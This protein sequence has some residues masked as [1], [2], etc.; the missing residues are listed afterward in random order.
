MDKA[1]KRIAKN[2]IYTYLSLIINFLA[3]LYTSRIVLQVLG[4]S[5]YGIYNVVSV[6]M[7][8]FAFLQGAL[9]TATT[10]TLNYEM[11]KPGGDVRKCFSVNVTLHLALA[12]IVLFIAETLGV[13][14]VDNVLVLP[15]GKLGDARF[16]FQISSLTVFL[17]LIV[18]PYRGLFAAHE[19]FGFLSILDIINTVLRVVL[20]YLLSLYNGQYA[21]RIFA[22]ITSVTT[23][24]TLIILLYVAKKRWKHIVKLQI[25]K[26]KKFYVEIFSFFNWKVLSTLSFLGR[27]SGT[28]LLMNSFFGTLTNG[29][30]GV[31]KTLNN[32]V[33]QFSVNF[34]AASGPQ[35]VKAYSAGDVNRYTYLANK[36]GR[37]TLILFEVIFF[38]LF[39][40][41]EYVLSLWLG[42]V[43]EGA[44]VFC[45]AYLIITGVSLTGG[46]IVQVIL[47]SG[48]IK[49]F[50]IQCSIFFLLCLPIGYVL[51]RNGYPAHSILYLFVIADVLQRIIQLVLAKRI[52]NFDSLRFIREA[53]ARPF[54]LAIIMSLIMFAYKYLTNYV[55]V[56]P[57]ITIAVFG[58]LTVI[59]A[60]F[61]GMTKQERTSLK[62]FMK[63]KF[64]LN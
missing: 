46:G 58:M 21:L 16:V 63:R 19:E 56:H 20:V 61:V 55:T 48:K 60:Y 42:N 33:C 30:F 37:L 35:I 64:R 47:A 41:L 1:N 15:E 31:A 22:L 27:S 38:T 24:N 17:S 45:K 26:D 32:M 12:V 36:I 13:W 50:E 8:L 49:W 54:Y 7:G 57:L 62:E 34:D 23:I 14:Y 53:Y 52:L 28:D 25:V 10:R 51:F 40:E 18:M 43:P 3:G 4:V 39:I 59:F 11:G 5:D 29:A 44:L 6:L 2:A 9:N